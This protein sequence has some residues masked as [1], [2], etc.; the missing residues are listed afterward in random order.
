VTDVVIIRPLRPLNLSAWECWPAPARFPNGLR[1]HS[2]ERWVHKRE[3]ISVLSTVEPIRD[4]GGELRPEYHVSLCRLIEGP[5]GAEPVRVDSATALDVLRLFGAE[6]LLEDNHVPSGKVRN[7]W[8]PVAD[9]I[10]DQQCAC[11]EVEPQIR[12]DRGDFVW[13][14]APE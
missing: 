7:F 1:P 4:D 9:P 8:R 12:E 10:A 5:F 13:R 3:R 2:A 11:V 14:A 6:K